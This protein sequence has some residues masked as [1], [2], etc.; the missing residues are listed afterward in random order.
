MATSS[1]YTETRTALQLITDSYLEAGGLIDFDDDLSNS[2][3][4]LTKG[5]RWLN[6]IIYQI[7]GPASG[8]AKSM[9][10]WQRES[11]SLTLRTNQYSYTFS[12]SSTDAAIQ[13]PEEIL[14]V[15]MRVTATTSDTPMKP[16]LLEEYQAITDKTETGTATKYYYEKR[17][18]TGTFY[19]NKAP[20]AAIASANTIEIVYRQPIE[21]ITASTNEMDVP[22]YW[23]R[24]LK[25]MLA[26][27]IATAFSVDQNDWD[28][29]NHLFKQ[30]IVLANIFDPEFIRIY[31]Q[32][33][34]EI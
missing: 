20:T 14:T 23:Y 31:D 15:N 13:V 32:P 6:D 4:L 9:K 18:T 24:A 28:R 22:N 25:F 7:K 29:V 12:P 11:T 21:I 19:I 27:D 10:M 34:R 26:L 16:M 2:P 33:Q 3:E 5:I 8:A 1:T 30:S 17:T